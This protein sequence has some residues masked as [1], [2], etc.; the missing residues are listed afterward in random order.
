MGHRA[1]ARKGDKRDKG[2]GGKKIGNA[3]SAINRIDRKFTGSER[4]NSH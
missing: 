3:D 2:M 1:E 4:G